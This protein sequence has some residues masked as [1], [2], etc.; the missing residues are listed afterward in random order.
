M[1]K[2]WYPTIKHV[3]GVDNDD[4]DD[5]LSWL[6]ILNKLSDVINWKNPFKYNLIVIER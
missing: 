6:D 5:V 1:L 3:A 2:E 4:D